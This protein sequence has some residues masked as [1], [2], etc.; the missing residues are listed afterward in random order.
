MLAPQYIYYLQGHL[1]WGN[2]VAT[3]HAFSGAVLNK[4][5]LMFDSVGS[6]FY[7][8]SPA[9]IGEMDTRHRKNAAYIIAAVGTE[10][11][12]L[13]LSQ[14]PAMSAPNRALIWGTTTLPV[15]SIPDAGPD[16]EQLRRIEA[17]DETVL[18]LARMMIEARR[19]AHRESS[20]PSTSVRSGR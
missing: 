15:A 5:S 20:H 17:N 10:E 4:R 3:C 16:G 9:F 12:R 11:S 1:V 2:A 13:D 7:N 18:E 14:I 6:E 8:F 19:Y